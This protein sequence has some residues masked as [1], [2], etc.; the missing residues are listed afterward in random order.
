MA[1]RRT[2][3]DGGGRIDENVLVAVADP[4]NT[5]AAVGRSRPVHHALIVTRTI[6][7]QLVVAERPVA[8]HPV[9]LARGVGSGSRAAVKPIF[10]G[11]F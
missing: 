7:N 11:T 3:I 6:Q 8:G 2:Q 1:R 9:A 5:V 10:V 4:C